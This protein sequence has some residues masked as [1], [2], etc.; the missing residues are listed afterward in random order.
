M[1]AKDLHLSFCIRS[2]IF[3]TKVKNYFFIMF[4]RLTIFLLFFLV[5]L[6]L[7]I[8]AQLAQ[9]A[10]TTAPIN[11]M[12]KLQFPHRI[13][14]IQAVEKQ[15]NGN[16]VQLQNYNRNNGSAQGYPLGTICHDTSER[17]FLRN[18]SIAFY[19]TDPLETA[20]GNIL[21]CGEYGVLKPPYANSGFLM[22][23]GYDGQVLW[24]K[25]YDSL[26]R[27]NTHF[28]DYYK[29]VELNDGSIFLAGTT[30]NQTTGHH[31]LILTKTD[32]SGNLIWSKVYQS[33]LWATAT[34]GNGT[35]DKYY[36]QQIKQ[37]PYTGNVYFV[38]PGP[39]STG[40]GAMSVV[41]VSP[42]NGNII[43]SR[44]YE[45][46]LVMDIPFGLDLRPNELRLI[47]QSSAYSSSFLGMFRI[48]KST[49]DTIQTKFFKTDDPDAAYLQFT[50]LEPLQ[51][52]N[53]GNYAISGECLGANPYT[54]N[55][56][57]PLYLAAMAQFDSN[58]NYVKAYCFRSRLYDPNG[59]STKTT[60][61]PDGS[62]LFSIEKYSYKPVYQMDNYL[63]QFRD[64]QILKQRKKNYIEHAV[65]YDPQGIRLKDGGD[66]LIRQLSYYLSDTAYL[67]FYKMH[68]SDT[69][70]SCLGV[71]ND[72]TFLYPFKYSPIYFSSLPIVSNVFQE[73]INKTIIV[74]DGLLYKLP[75]CYQVS[76]CG[77][78]KLSPSSNI[79]CL[80]QS[81][82]L[83]AHRNTG[84][85]STVFWKFDTTST[86]AIV[87]SNDTTINI[88]FKA[89]WSGY[90]Y[91][92]IMGCNTITD[93]VFISVVQ[94]PTILSL[95]SDTS[96][97]PNNTIKLNAHAG[98]A[99]YKW[100]DGSTDSIFLVK[101]PGRYFVQATD[102]CGG[103]FD[104]T[105]LVIAQIPVPITI[106]PD[107]I[108]CNNDTVHLDVPTG[109]LNYQWSPNYNINLANTFS[110]IVNPL[111][112][113]AY[114]IRAEQPLGCF[115][116]DTVNITVLHSPLINLGNDTSLCAGQTLTLNAGIGFANYNW[117]SG[118]SSPTIS[119]YMSGTYNIVGTSPN[120]CR[121]YDTLS[122]L[123][124]N[125]LPI[126][127]LD[128]NENLC[129][130]NERIL[131]AGLFSFYHWQD[132]STARTF[133]EFG[134]GRYY[135]NVTDENGCHGSDTTVIAYILPIPKGFLFGDTS[136][137][138]YQTITL[139][140]LKN[141]ASYLWNT[142]SLSQS[143][144]IS[145]PG[146]YWLQVND[147]NGCLGR[148]SITV[149]QKQCMT[150][151]FVPTGFTPNGDSK[152][153][154]LRALLF[155][156][157]QSFDFVVYNRYGQKVFETK[158]NTEGWDGTINGQQQALGL[159]VWVCKY[160]LVG[161]TEIIERGTTILIK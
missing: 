99:V 77:S 45:T 29:M 86:S 60:I 98:Y 68:I 90:I 13:Q 59:N 116:F 19:G 82:T 142:G 52:L 145:K 118:P 109:F 88:R 72:S 87:Q 150:G 161:Q 122:V 127:T 2:Q 34:K 54:W 4:Y 95:G 14:P 55:G 73:N 41:D 137:C 47:S 159:Y 9:R 103:N 69:S 22:K 149:V 12:R 32:N 151:L 146:I 74:K 102:A 141:Y 6:K 94:A 42:M 126:V 81:V 105:I 138:S 28:I 20:D 26:N 125:A 135:V 23:L 97:C 66:L 3:V 78:I 40:L 56:T 111:V 106:G 16:L 153:D 48:N 38:G 140:P 64:G 79:V 133:T 139:Q 143:I 134:L 11:E 18:D 75:A 131:D 136:I 51:I 91:G 96:I 100:Q 101:H 121:S 123:Y 113:T 63:I 117:G 120:G 8:S 30:D 36:I 17:F 33:R 152:N 44:S 84:C 46:A 144:P 160:K 110:A 104:D 43:W 58:F 92:S 5:F 119:V 37:D 83:I 25:T 65:P 53:N 57:I 112:D 80:S 62:G 67:E 124:V 158:I 157:I 21:L 148:D 114:F 61:F 24:Y 27:S 31:D 1:I 156:E 93:S 76:F 39:D 155:G 15:G 128:H 115:S 7:D 35:M 85:G 50:N 71:E 154:K 132:G 147:N 89:Q 130:G 108:K 10:N 129:A 70:S 107:R 49:G